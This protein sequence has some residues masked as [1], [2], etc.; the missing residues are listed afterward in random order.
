M[1]IEL[2]TLDDIMYAKEECKK[3]GMRLMILFH[4]KYCPYCTTLFPEWMTASHKKS[5]VVFAHI[6]CSNNKQVFKN[7]FKFQTFPNIVLYDRDNV[8]QITLSQ[9][10]SDSIFRAATS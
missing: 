5:K 9:R 4:L 7:A 8:K 3:N 10:N 1:S 6:E 2:R